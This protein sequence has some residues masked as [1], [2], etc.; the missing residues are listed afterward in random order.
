MQLLSIIAMWI[1]SPINLIAA[2]FDHRNR[3]R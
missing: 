2:P 3:A 1:H